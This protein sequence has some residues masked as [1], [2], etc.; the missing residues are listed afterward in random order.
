MQFLWVRW[1]G[2]E[3]GHRSGRRHARLP[4]LGFVPDSDPYAFSFLDPSCIIRGAHIIPAFA[5][6]KSVNLLA[7]RH[8]MARPS[9]SPEDWINFYVDIFVDRDMFFRYLGCGIG[10][11]DIVKALDDALEAEDPDE[12]YGSDDNMDLDSAPFGSGFIFGSD[13]EE[14]DDD[15]DDDDLD[16]DGVDDEDDDDGDDDDVGYGGL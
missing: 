4:K 2:V 8:T 3:P 12:P 13:G 7:A 6:G 11:L 10:H 16:D 14:S 15:K 1:L 5:A 9:T